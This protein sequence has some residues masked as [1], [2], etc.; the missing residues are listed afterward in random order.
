[1]QEFPI[2]WQQTCPVSL[3]LTSLLAKTE[4]HSEPVNLKIQSNIKIANETFIQG[5]QG[6]CLG[7]LVINEKQI[8][9]N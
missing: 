9:E 5:D 1:V 3:H 8:K 7:I 2:T 4:F 6:T